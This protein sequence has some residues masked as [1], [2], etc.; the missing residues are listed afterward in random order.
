[1]TMLR[2]TTKLLNLRPVMGPIWLSCLLI[3]ILLWCIGSSM[4]TQLDSPTY[5]ASVAFDSSQL[6]HYLPRRP[7][8]A[9]ER[10]QLFELWNRGAISQHVQHAVPSD[11][12]LAPL[13]DEHHF[14]P[15]IA[16]RIIAAALT[17]GPIAFIL[18]IILWGRFLS[19]VTPNPTGYKHAARTANVILACATIHVPLLLIALDWYS[20]L[21]SHAHA[22]GLYLTPIAVSNPTLITLAAFSIGIYPLVFFHLRWRRAINSPDATHCPKCNYERGTL[23]TC[24]ECGTPRSA[25]STKLST[26]KRRILIA[27]YAAI[28]LL[29]IAP[30]WISWI[31]IAI[32]HLTN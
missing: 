6:T 19:G 9:A 5:R 18:H 24:P 10:I 12:F 14:E 4:V 21:F 23:D 3:L 2:A 8:Q 29:L 17:I 31:D 27:G 15:G 7:A 32:Y 13:H 11:F 25:P 16:L 20:F 1:M 28:P 30:F 22:L 26:A